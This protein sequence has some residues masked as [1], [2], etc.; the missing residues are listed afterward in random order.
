MWY[1]SG[2]IEA[3]ITLAYN[4]GEILLRMRGDAAVT[5]KRDGSPVTSAD[6]ASHELIKAGLARYGIPVLS[7]E[8]ENVAESPDGQLWIVDPL[9]GTRAY[10]TGGDDFAVSIALVDHDIPT[11]GVIYVPATETLYFA[12]RGKGAFMRVKETEIRVGVSATDAASQASCVHG[13]LKSSRAIDFKEF[14]IRAFGVTRF[15][16]RS[17]VAVRSGLIAQGETD[18]ML[19][20][21]KFGEWDVAAGHVIIEEAG[22]VVTDLSGKPL[23]YHN[24][25]RHIQNGIIASNTA[26]HPI[27]LNA[28]K[29]HKR[30]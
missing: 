7:E 18:F 21:T 2:M 10:I 20:N 11:L 9:D 6:L 1:D 24:A 8:S 13:M 14:I 27:L 26:L 5:I 3:V 16:E 30:R 25:D 22:G 15:L 29:E 12:E 4:A 19:T 17:S 28:L 23:S